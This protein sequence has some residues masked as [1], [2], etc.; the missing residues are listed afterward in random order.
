MNTFRYIFLLCVILLLSWLFFDKIYYHKSCGLSQDQINVISTKE[1]NGVE[2][3]VMDK[4]SGWNDKIY[5][6]LL[7]AY[8]LTSDDCGNILST[9]IDTVGYMPDILTDNPKKKIK[10]LVINN[11]LQLDEY[12]GGEGKFISVEWR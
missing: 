8:P 10:V 12:E 1:I 2:Y 5:S 7:Y 6:L 11:K 9:P 3:A 4:V